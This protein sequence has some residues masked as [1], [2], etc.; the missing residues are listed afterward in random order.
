ML[1]LGVIVIIV[2]VVYKKRCGSQDI[3]NG[4]IEMDQYR[5][6]TDG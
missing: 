2:V 6:V 3:N 5:K 1:M 4:N